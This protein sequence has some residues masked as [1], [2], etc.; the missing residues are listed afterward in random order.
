M[1]KHSVCVRVPN[2]AKWARVPAGS[3]H[4]GKLPTAGS[5]LVAGL[6]ARALAPST[7]ATKEP[8]GTAGAEDKK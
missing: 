3:P 1:K 2:R 5:A 6:L 4:W 8:Q 7:D